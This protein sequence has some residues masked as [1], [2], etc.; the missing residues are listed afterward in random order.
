MGRYLSAPAHAVII[1][2]DTNDYLHIH[3]TEKDKV[4]HDTMAGIKGMERIW[5]ISKAPQANGEKSPVSSEISAH[6]RFPVVVFIR[7]GHR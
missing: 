1:S 7:F 6:T 3:P 4:N 2:G 5:I